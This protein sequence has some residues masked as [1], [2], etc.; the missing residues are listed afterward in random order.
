MGAGRRAVSSKFETYTLDL[1]GS[2]Q[3]E[4]ILERVPFADLTEVFLLCFA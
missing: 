2:G 4:S 3:Q 1:R